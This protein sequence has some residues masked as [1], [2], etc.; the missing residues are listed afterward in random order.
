MPGNDLVIELGRIL[1]P[2]LAHGP[3]EVDAGVVELALQ[4][5]H[6][7]QAG[8]LGLPAGLQLVELRLLAVHVGT[9]FLEA[10]LGGLRLSPS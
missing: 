7:V 1:V 9:E 8:L 6:A 5:A 2:L 3:I 4:V 10:I